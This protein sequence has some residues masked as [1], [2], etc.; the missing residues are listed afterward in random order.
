MHD[1]RFS[2]VQF[3]SVQL[4]SPVELF[5]T[6][7]TVAPQASL[8]ITNSQS[9]PKP[10]SIESVMPSNHLILCHPLLL[11]PSIF[12]SIRV[13]SNETGRKK[14]LLLWN[15]DTGM[16]KLCQMKTEGSSS[17][18]SIADGPLL[19]L[20]AKGDSIREG[21][22]H[23]WLEVLVN[24]RGWSELQPPSETVLLSV[25]QPPE[26]AEAT[27]GDS[28]RV[29]CAFWLTARDACHFYRGWEDL[30]IW[31]PCMM[32]GHFEKEKKN[33]NKLFYESNSK[34]S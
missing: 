19:A 1:V 20:A 34:V 33:W 16:L 3:S 24:L 28:T 7:W 30:N 13:F 12:P 17:M 6:P 5:L 18:T 10:M 11:L 8:S 14:F 29:L 32:M 27:G 31:S 23:L 21:W 22:T 25:L 9:P 15:R 26:T 4:L 2:L